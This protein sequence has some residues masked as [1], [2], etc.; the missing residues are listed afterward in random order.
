MF[1]EELL[2]STYLHESAVD[3]HRET[4]QETVNKFPQQ[5]S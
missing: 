2:V 4:K 3:L 1:K 5:G